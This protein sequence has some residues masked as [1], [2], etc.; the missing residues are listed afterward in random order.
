MIAH[1]RAEYLH[2]FTGMHALTDYTIHMSMFPT[3]KEEKEFQI[4]ADFN[5]FIL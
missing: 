5:F 3:S 4:M 2:S 1:A